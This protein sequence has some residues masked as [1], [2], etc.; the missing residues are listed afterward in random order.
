M[1]NLIVIKADNNDDLPVVVSNKIIEAHFSLPLGEQRLLYTYISKLNDELEEFPELNISALEFADMVGLAD[2]NYSNI[3]T[4]VDN[5]MDRRLAID[6]EDEYLTFHWFSVA[7]YVKK[8]GRI[9]LK[10]HDELKPYFLRLRKEFT[11]FVVGQL[12]KFKSS[13]SSRIYMLCKQYQAFGNRLFEIGDLRK[14]LEIKSDKYKLYGHFK[15]KIL[16]K[17]VAEINSTSDIEIKFHEIK[18]G[19]KVTE[20]L[21]EIYKNNK[22]EAVK[23]RIMEN[24]NA[25]PSQEISMM[26]KEEIKKRWQ[27]D[28]TI[29]ELIRYEKETLLELLSLILRGIYEDKKILAPRVYFK[30]TLDKIE[31]SI[32]KS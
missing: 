20:I 30:S 8:E 26:V 16:E 4:Q 18:E 11:K 13:Y 10:I 6:T 24:Y 32:L 14:T 22:N 2:P 21:F 5:L 25:L 28:F 23:E 17:A 12:I 9:R 7:R 3:R 15:S 1:G 27:E 29:A 31:M 19:R